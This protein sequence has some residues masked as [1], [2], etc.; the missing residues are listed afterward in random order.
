MIKS[1][2][3]DFGANVKTG[4]FSYYPNNI[5][6]N[7][8]KYS[9]KLKRVDHEALTKNFTFSAHKDDTLKQR[10]IYVLVIGETSR[11]HNWG[12]YGYNRN[13]SPR[14]EKRQGLLPFTDA[15]TAGAM[16]ELSVPLII[17]RATPEDF[18]RHFREKG[19]G[20]AFDESGFKTYWISNQ[21]DYFHILMH[22]KEMDSVVDLGGA[23]SSTHSVYDISVVNEFENILK[24]D[25]NQK[26]FYILHT[27]GS[28][29][30]YSMRYPQN[31]EVFKP[32]GQNQAINPMNPANKGILVN[33]YDNSILYT[34][35][36]LDSLISL[37]DK[38]K[39]V[40]Y[41]LYL[42]DHGEDLYDDSRM[43]FLHPPTKPTAFVAH[44][45][46]FIW[47]STL[48]DSIYPRKYQTLKSHLNSPISS[49]NVFET[50]LDMADISFPGQNLSESIASDSFQN[51]KQLLLGGDMKVYRF[52]DLK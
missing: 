45:P 36:I 21:D 7:V 40:S 44:I 32:A 3:R 15:S 8:F 50:L 11:A 4:L 46:F 37:L 16:T 12:L 51:S 19:V 10:E 33:S 27:M 48:Y 41:L 23:R 42:S 17:T 39:A 25:K 35:M 1:G 28:H 24:H 49:H 20:A 31:F 30:N 14:L 38:E 2:T 47:T 26:S 9:K 5:V 13:T 34:D 52:K 43:K 6:Y 22:K 18:D 29:F